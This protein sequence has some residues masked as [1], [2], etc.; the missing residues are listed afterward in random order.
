MQGVAGHLRGQQRQRRPVHVEAL[1]TRPTDQPGQRA[2]V[3][4]IA[5]DRQQRRAH[6]A[7][8][9]HRRSASGG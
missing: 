8:L 5:G 2:V 4:D 1:Y 6:R 9:T 3:A 7:D